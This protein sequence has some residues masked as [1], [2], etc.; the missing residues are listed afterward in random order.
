MSSPSKTSHLHATKHNQPTK[1]RRPSHHHTREEAERDT[2]NHTPKHK[3]HPHPPHHKNIPVELQSPHVLQQKLK[4]RYQKYRYL[5]HLPQHTNPPTTSDG[6]VFTRLATHKQCKHF[7]EELENATPHCEHHQH[8]PPSP[9]FFARLATPKPVPPPP[10]PIQLQPKDHPPPSK[11]A[12][13]RLSKPRVVY[14]V[15]QYEEEGIPKECSEWKPMSHKLVMSEK[16]LQRMLMISR[17]KN[18]RELEEKK[19]EEEEKLA[20]EAATQSS[21]PVSVPSS[22]P[23]GESGGGITDPGQPVDTN[24]P[25]ESTAAPTES[26]N[27]TELEQRQPPISQG[28]EPDL[29]HESVPESIPSEALPEMATASDLVPTEEPVAQKQSAPAS[30]RPTAPPSKR[31]SLA[32]LAQKIS[33]SLQNLGT[34]KKRA[35]TIKVDAD[36]P[37]SESTDSVLTQPTEEAV[38]QQS[39]E[40]TEVLAPPDLTASQEL[41]LSL[42]PSQAT[43]EQKEAAVKLQATFRGFQARKK[44]KGESMEKLNEGAPATDVAPVTLEA[45]TLVEAIPTEAGPAAIVESSNESETVVEAKDAVVEEPLIESEVPE[46][47]LEPPTE[48]IPPAQETAAPEEVLNATEQPAAEGDIEPPTEPIEVPAEAPA[49]IPT[50][51]P[52]EV[53][54]EVEPEPILE[55]IPSQDP[56]PETE[57]QKTPLPPKNE[58]KPTLTASQELLLNLDPRQ[59]TEEQKDAATKLQA[60]FRGFQARKK[61]KG[62]SLEKL[63]EG[64]GSQVQLAATETTAQML[65]EEDAPAGTK[66]SMDDEVPLG[67]IQKQIG[68][69]IEQF[70]TEQTETVAEQPLETTDSVPA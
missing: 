6:S 61:L 39:E 56:T 55:A 44:L 37:P 30:K 33:Q 15:H 2:A 41:L 70:G 54:T 11:D 12:I 19:K 49:E 13:E 31:S 35:S 48:A 40:A 52:I 51:V 3:Y 14:P 69:T 42:D 21:A 57:P 67:L 53:A 10:Q 62:E 5:V 66:S 38:S 8:A 60:T 32:N 20:A 26:T 4:T 63:N 17:P 25:T 45:D 59:A 29:P 27:T 64:S 22:A 34:P 23:D 47:N 43:D 65:K 28:I 50:E 36:A 9:D 68:Q 18:W 58:A 24:I 46:A 7:L 16:Q 1:L